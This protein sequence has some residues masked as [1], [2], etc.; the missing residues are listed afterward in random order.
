MEEK[1]LAALVSTH[2]H[3][4]KLST[5]NAVSVSES[6]TQNLRPQEM[7]TVQVWVLSSSTKS[8]ASSLVT[9][10]TWLTWGHGKG[11]MW[12]EATHNDTDLSSPVKLS[13]KM[14]MFKF[15]P[16]LGTPRPCW[17]PDIDHFT[18]SHFFYISSQRKRKKNKRCMLVLCDTA[19]K[20]QGQY[21]R[22]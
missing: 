9:H 16:K 1:S 14:P 19:G 20:C 6:P 18:G 7:V 21:N 10:S 22:T 15:S 4:Q 13:Y 3:V 17:E 12:T 11:K 5:L 8:L 2:H